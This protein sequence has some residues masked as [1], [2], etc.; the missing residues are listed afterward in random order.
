MSASTLIT[1]FLHRPYVFAFLISFFIIGVLNRGFIRTVLF[2]ILGFGVAFLSEVSSIRN[3][4]PYG[5]YHYVYENLQ[6]EWIVWGVPV[7][8]SL[9]YSFLAYAAYEYAD[10]FDGGERWVRGRKI[11]VTSVLM[12]LLDVVV[13]PLAVRGDRWFLGRIFYYPN[14]GDYFGVP[15]TNFGGWLL[16]A[17]A[18]LFLYALLESFFENPPPRRFSL[19]GPLFYWGILIFNLGITFWIGEVLLGILGLGL[20][21]FTV[22]ALSSQHRR[23]KRAFL[24]LPP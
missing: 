3:G 18:I 20:H 13:D 7:W 23:R 10:Y 2:L 12:L 1:T 21:L 11:I 14:G 22:F 19:L 8:D 9:S 4:F 15:V 5:L 24:P 16:V 6:G 17:F